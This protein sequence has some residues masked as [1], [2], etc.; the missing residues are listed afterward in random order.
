[1]MIYLGIIV[2]L[3]KEQK[4]ETRIARVVQVLTTKSQHTLPPIILPDIYQALTLCKVGGKF[5]TRYSILLQMLLVEHHRDH[6]RYMS[7]GP[8]VNNYIKKYEERVNDYNSL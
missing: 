2:S 4:I 7:H 1:M 6:P 5:F 3:D 8:N